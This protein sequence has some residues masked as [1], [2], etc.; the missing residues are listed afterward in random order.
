MLA[1]GSTRGWHISLPKARLFKLGGEKQNEANF[2]G[3]AFNFEGL[4]KHSGAF[5][6]K[7]PPPRNKVA[8]M[9]SF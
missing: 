3:C 6:I 1:F 4:R 2:K 7:P 9:K 8:T 5:Q